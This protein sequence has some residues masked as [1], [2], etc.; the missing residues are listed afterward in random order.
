M[1]IFNKVTPVNVSSANV[2]E[3]KSNPYSAYGF[4]N[5]YFVSNTGE[6]FFPKTGVKLLN[7]DVGESYRKLFSALNGMNEAE[8]ASFFSARD[9][10]FKY[11]VHAGNL[12]KEIKNASLTSE[13][14]F[15]SQFSG[16]LLDADTIK[17]LWAAVATASSPE[18]YIDVLRFGGEGARKSGTKLA[19]KAPSQSV[20]EGLLDDANALIES[21]SLMA[22]FTEG[23]EYAFT[24]TSVVLAEKT[25]A[26]EEP[27]FEL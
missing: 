7:K 22:S 24:P 16:G 9:I 8:L 13:E 11:E 5:G 2:A 23:K 14:A 6:K 26:Q 18:K 20:K 15:S 4:I 25:E 3:V 21:V 12:A 17:A 27:D 10:S 1:S 19:F